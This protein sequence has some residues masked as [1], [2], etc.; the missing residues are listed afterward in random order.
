MDMRILTAGVIVLAAALT[1][2]PVRAQRFHEPQTIECAS[3]GYRFTRCDAPWYDARLVEQ[4]SET[5]CTRGQTWGVD[6]QGL[7]V[8]GGCAGVFRREGGYDDRDNGG[9]Y[10]HGGGWHPDRDWDTRFDI[11]CASYNYAYNFCG[12]DVGGGGR[13]RLREQVSNSPCREGR[14]WGWNRAGIWVNG[15]CEAV[16]EVD[17]RWR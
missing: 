12:V 17:R 11:R 9:G 14:N 4:T 6:R 1:P 15:G 2:Q 10:G 7:W 16:F 3:E 8:K 13:V 5:R